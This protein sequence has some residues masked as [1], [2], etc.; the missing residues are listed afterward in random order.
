[1]WVELSAINKAI[2]SGYYAPELEIKYFYIII[3]IVLSDGTNNNN[4]I[5][6]KS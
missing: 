4:Y 1:M 3:T 5:A 6:N 2:K